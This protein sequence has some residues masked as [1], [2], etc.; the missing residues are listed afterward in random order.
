LEFKQY[1]RSLPDLGLNLSGGIHSRG[2]D[3]AQDHPGN[4]ENGCSQANEQIF[5]SPGSI[6]QQKK[7]YYRN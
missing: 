2:L 7:G 5:L 3:G 1:R 4:N 6:P